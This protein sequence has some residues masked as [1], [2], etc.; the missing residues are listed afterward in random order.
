ME[1]TEPKLFYKNKNQPNKSELELVPDSYENTALF[2]LE[3][4]ANY[5]IIWPS[6]KPGWLKWMVVAYIALNFH[7]QTIIYLF[8]SDDLALQK[9]IAIGELSYAW[10]FYSKMISGIIHNQ[11][12]RQVLDDIKLMWKKCKTNTILIK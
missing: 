2:T 12:L 3:K 10:L 9:I 8:I 1:T 4:V 7:V 11:K 6:S 5:Y